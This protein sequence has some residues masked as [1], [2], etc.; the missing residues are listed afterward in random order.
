MPRNKCNKKY[1]EN[2]NRNTQKTKKK[3]CHVWFVLLNCLEAT[4]GDYYRLTLVCLTRV[5]VV[6]VAASSAYAVRVAGTQGATRERGDGGSFDYEICVRFIFFLAFFAHKLLRSLTIWNTKCFHSV[7]HFDGLDSGLA[8]RCC[9][10]GSRC[11]TGTEC[12]STPGKMRQ[13]LEGLGRKF[14]GLLCK[15]LCEFAIYNICVDCKAPFP[16]ACLLV[17]CWYFVV[18][19]VGILLVYWLADCSYCKPICQRDLSFSLL[20]DFSLSL[21]ISLSI[22]LCLSLLSSLSQLTFLLAVG[23]SRLGPV[24]PGGMEAING[25]GPGW[26]KCE[27]VLRL[28]TGEF[29]LFCM[30]RNL[31]R[32]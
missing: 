3:K 27:E 23:V 22:C 5:V 30:C 11:P 10:L 6:V 12:L 26:R 1:Q 17:F 15:L 32:L 9:C 29:N 21:S 2:T 24:L 7:D 25:S 31:C 16:A 19:F 4:L 18:R 8:A 20:P 13:C 14:V 28:L